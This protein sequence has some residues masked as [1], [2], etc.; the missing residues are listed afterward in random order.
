MDKTSLLHEKT[1]IDSSRKASK[2]SFTRKEKESEK[3][4]HHLEADKLKK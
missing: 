3:G 2:I 1:L 4:E